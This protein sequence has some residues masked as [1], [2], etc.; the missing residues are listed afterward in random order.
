MRFSS[1]IKEMRGVLDACLAG[2]PD[3]WRALFDCYAVC[4]YRALRGIGAAHELAE[5]IAGDVF[6]KIMENRSEKLRSA[7]FESETHLRWWLITI[8]RNLFIDHLRHE[9]RKTTF[10]D[11]DVHDFRLAANSESHHENATHRMVEKISNRR[12]IDKAFSLLTP[13]ERYYTRLYYYEGLKYKEIAKLAGV[14]TGG[15]ASLIARAK[16]KLKRAL[17]QNDLPERL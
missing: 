14:T 16:A 11:G 3:G 4:L 2:D 8:A 15:V 7:T 13:R 9:R 5:D 12:E 1:V 17:K 10:R 6:V